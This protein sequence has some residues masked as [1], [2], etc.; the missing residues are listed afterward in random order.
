MRKRGTE[1][2]QS[3]RTGLQMY[4]RQ[5]GSQ[6][7]RGGRSTW[8]NIGAETMTEGLIGIVESGIRFAYVATSF[9]Y[10]R[11]FATLRNV[12]TLRTYA[13]TFRYLPSP[14]LPP[15][16][17][18]PKSPPFSLYIVVGRCQPDAYAHHVFA[19]LSPS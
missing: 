14:H 18:Y 11:R 8:S 2:K 6:R 12:E 4:V 19:L 17:T 13:E 10:R 7:T 15:P 3:I 16:F 9:Y 1:W 5:P